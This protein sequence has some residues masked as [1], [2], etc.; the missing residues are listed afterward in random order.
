MLRRNKSWSVLPGERTCFLRGTHADAMVWRSLHPGFLPGGSIR[1]P[2]RTCFP[3]SL[4]PEFFP[5]GSIRKPTR[6]FFPTALFRLLD[7]LPD[8]P[9]DTKALVPG[10]K[11]HEIFQILIT[12]P[13]WHSA[14]QL[15]E[16]AKALLLSASTKLE[17]WEAFTV[18]ARALAAHKL[19]GLYC[20]PE[21][22]NGED[23]TTYTDALTRLIF[24]VV[25]YNFITISKDDTI[26]LKVVK[27]A[28]TLEVGPFAGV[29]SEW[30]KRVGSGAYKE[31]IALVSDVHFSM[32]LVPPPL[33][34]LIL[35]YAMD[36]FC[37]E[38]LK[39]CTIYR[40]LNYQ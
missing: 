22:K 6:P 5:G 37:V 3:R 17:A 30:Y 16:V 7:F 39:K 11:V 40:L 38:S 4:H 13:K 34:D 29:F 9:L 14:M 28:A 2:E 10:L 24:I 31:L 19:L 21:N 12:E 18:E 32:D 20:L 27:H 35:E 15:T 1:K 8:D 25:G 36:P 33:V 26:W 23:A